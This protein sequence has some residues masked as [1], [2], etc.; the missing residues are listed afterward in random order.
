MENITIDVNHVHIRGDIHGCFDSE[1][2]ELYTPGISRLGDQDVLL[3]SGDSGAVFYNLKKNLNYIDDE[4]KQMKF[5]ASRKYKIIYVGGNHENY[6]RLLS[7][8]QYEFQDVKVN[9]AKCKRILDNLYYLQNGEVIEFNGS[10]FLA[11]GGARSIDKDS[12]VPHVNWWEQEIPSEG[13][14]EKAFKAINDSEIDYVISHTASNPTIDELM[15]LYP[16]KATLLNVKKSHDELSN[17][18]ELVRSS[19]IP[20][21]FGHFHIDAD[22]S[23]NEFCCYRKLRKII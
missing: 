7:S 4:K 11:I 23:F 22:L 12:R 14:I 8:E 6:D 10:K 17:F 5:I 15:N 3:I 9:G 18:L 13:E 2:T 20:H 16:D 19:S 1:L 21:Y